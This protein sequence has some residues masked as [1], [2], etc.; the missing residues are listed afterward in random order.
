M[1][2]TLTLS[3]GQASSAG[4]KPI[5]Q[6]HMGYHIPDKPLL[7]AK[8][9]VIA[10]ADGI[11]SSDVSHI[12]S[13][14][15]IGSFV[16]DYYSTSDAWSVKN[17][18]QKVLKSTNYWLHSQTQSSA[19][20]YEPDRGYVCT[21]S[22]IVFKSNTAHLFHCGDSRIYRLSGHSLEQ[23]TSDHRRVI[24]PHT[25]YLS[26]GLGI[27]TTLDIDYRETTL[28]VGDIFVLTTDG[29][30]EFLTNTEMAK[31]VSDE[32]LDLD[33]KAE[34]LVERAL[35]LGSDDNLTVQIVLIEQ[36]P[37]HG[38]SELAHQVTALPP[39]PQLQV[40]QRFDG[41]QILRE[42]HIS[43]RSHVFLAK[44]LDTQQLVALK[45]PSVE[46]RNDAKYLESFLMEDW[47]A[48]RLNNPHVLKA[49]ASLRPKKYVY[50]VSEFIEGKSLSQWMK[51]NPQPSLETVRGIVAQIAKGLLAF[52]RQEMVHQDL[53]PNNIMIDDSG[54][55]KIIDFGATSVAGIAETEH[56]PTGIPGTAQYCAPEY[57]LGELGDHRSD[58]FSLGVITYQLLTGRLPYGND[59]A[60]AHN[61]PAQQR[62]KYITSSDGEQSVPMWVD[63]AL[64]RAVSI[65]PD[66][67]YREVSEFIHDL[68]TPNPKARSLQ[69]MPI[70][71]RNPV[72][73]WQRISLVL[74]IALTVSVV[75]QVT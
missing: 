3:V 32:R 11:S 45:T 22:G 74:A 37:E 21:F 5:N 47:I 72:L 34:L 67:R 17:S 46:M 6:D 65:R 51:D 58:M 28:N 15:A 54:T 10:I 49:Q 60:K 16:A 61:R 8:G 23:M 18:A 1:T 53:R 20:R 71:E 26:R 57:F 73:F 63:Y 39:A 25:S 19:F 38:Y 29:V 40:K 13:E 55:V 44:D 24:D 14:T 59:I 69:Q 4:I 48:T 62:L 7:N 41:Y 33:S 64:K 75:T 66:K 68:T 52:H 31:I 9:A 12:A 36:L 27:E 35:Q 2:Q 56:T 50:S 30:H 43:S 42:I 70:I